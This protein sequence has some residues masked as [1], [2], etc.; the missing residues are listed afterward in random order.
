MKT[1]D[2]K[3]ILVIGPSGVGKSCL[4]CHAGEMI[5]CIVVFD[6]DKEIR[7]IHGPPSK[8]LPCVGADKFFELSIDIIK[9]IQAN[10]RQQPIIV[11][12]AGSLESNNS[13]KL[14]DHGDLLI[15]WASAEVSFER[16][17][18]SGR[19]YQNNLSEY[20]NREYD[21][22]KRMNIYSTHRWKFCNEE[23]LQRAKDEFVGFLQNEVLKVVSS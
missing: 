18:S 7:R 9:D 22:Q 3:P 1:E 19:P 23:S 4:C 20:K 14:S 16:A 8:L 15:A 13:I 6:L 10:S 17:C 12:G 5:D 21:V 2:R 11:V